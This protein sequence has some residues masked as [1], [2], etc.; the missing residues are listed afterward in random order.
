MPSPT[1]KRVLATSVPFGPDICT[2]GKHV[3]GAWDG[4]TLIAVG[5]TRA[6]ALRKYR[7]A[8]RPADDG[9]RAS[10]AHRQDEAFRKECK[11]LEARVPRR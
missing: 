4:P 5:A 10:V 3:W 9:Y 7:D 11:R 2:R 1:L 6:E 8:F